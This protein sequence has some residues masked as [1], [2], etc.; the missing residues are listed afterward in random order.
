M[1]GDL[2]SVTRF[3]A[4]ETLEDQLREELREVIDPE[5]GIDVLSLGLVYGF[6]LSGRT[7]AVLLTTTTPA[8]PLGDYLTD[9]VRRVLLATGAVDDVLVELTHSPLWSPDL[10]SDE[11]KASF[12]W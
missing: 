7:A 5:L 9:E 8:C 4:A 6:E 12:G 2:L 3:L 10:M 11:A 1:T